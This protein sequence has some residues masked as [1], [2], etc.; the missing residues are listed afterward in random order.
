[1]LVYENK[2]TEEIVQRLIALG[3]TIRI[4]TILG[5]I[6]LVA[7]LVAQL[8]SFLVTGL[9]FWAGALIGILVGYGLGSFLA[10]FAT[11]TIE[12]MA[13]LLVAQGEI[14]AALRER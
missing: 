11:L 1:M 8:G 10:A 6:V 13:Q 9:P 4:L 3:N 7:P 14:L 12:W 2:R 5:T